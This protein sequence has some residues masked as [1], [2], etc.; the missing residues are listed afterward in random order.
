MNI[1]QTVVEQAENETFLGL[2]SSFPNC[3]QTDRA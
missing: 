2:L 1:Y 3:T